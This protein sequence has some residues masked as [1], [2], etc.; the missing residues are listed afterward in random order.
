MRRSI[1]LMAF[2]VLVSMILSACASAAAPATKTALPNPLPSATASPTPVPPKVLTVCLGFEPQ[3]LYLYARSDRSM[4]SV[5]EA[6]YDGPFDT[7]NYLPQPVI[8]KK[9]PSLADGDVRLSAVDV[10]PGQPVIN[11]A[12]DLVSLAQ[13]VQV[14]PSGCTQ[15]D[16]ALTYDGQSA[17]KMDQAQI[18]YTLLEGLKWSDGQPLTADDSVFSYQ[19][20]ADPATPVNRKV[21]DRTASYTAQDAQTV[22]WTGVAG[23]LPQD[24]S[25]FFWL[26]LPKHQ[27]EAI[28]AAD[29]LTSELTNR[30]PLGWGPY[31]IV[32]WTPGDHIR[33]EKNP[34]Y[35][36]AAEGLPK[37]DVLV[38][39]FVSQQQDANLVALS[40]GE[41][42]L[43]DASSLV[44]SQYQAV[45][46]MELDKKVKVFTSLGPEW[47]HLD[48]GI[49]P[50]SYDDGYNPQSGDRPDFFSDVRVR[51]AFAYCLDR[52]GAAQAAFN[53]YAGAVP[54]SY[55]T[56]NH[57]DYVTG[58]TQYAFD[59]QKGAQLL[60]QAGWVDDDGKPDTPRVA[61]SAQTVLSG[62]KLELTYLVSQ[63]AFSRVVADVLASSLKQC[64]IGV[65]VQ[66]LGVDQLYAPAPD[67]VLFGRKFD[68]AQFAWSMGKEPPCYLYVSSEIP[69]AQNDWLG[70]KYG[71]VNLTGYQNPAYDQ[72]CQAAQSA[73]LDSAAALA[74]QQQVEKILADDLPVIPLFF[75]PK[76]VIT[77]PEVCGVAPDASARSLLWN[78]E[79][80]DKGDACP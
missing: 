29:L 2:L 38:F 59:P 11:T 73:G 32:E 57:P 56:P 41:C 16:C 18:T 26:P 31:R 42:D 61:V 43:V 10:K 78:I 25:A 17:L 55:L 70:Q 58:L 24:T 37:F 5:L 3:S 30:S 62:T 47:E 50:A 1:N 7:K 54:D 46:Q 51:Q 77:K 35:F 60:E 40:T 71:G 75:Y 45:R 63:S 69:S 72:A 20:A 9:L 64:G 66:S 13:G 52:A 14:F 36:R 48:F 53:S 67:G 33:L 68:L 76:L 22:I 39:R 65:T 27:L 80:F 12:G 79:A 28:S 6:I 19:V 8:L 21:F 4:W 34:N 15:S 74:S 23:Y 44:Q 49:L